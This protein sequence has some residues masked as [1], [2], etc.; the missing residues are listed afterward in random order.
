MPGKRVL[1]ADD[2]KESEADLRRIIEGLGH[3]WVAS[4]VETGTA[5]ISA[6]ERGSFTAV[7]TET[8]L[9]DMTGVELLEKA[10]GVSP[11]TL[12][13][14]MA[15][16]PTRDIIVQ[17]AGC[18]HQLI[19]KPVEPSVFR[20]TLENSQGLHEILD[21]EELQATLASIDS[22]PTRPELYDELT[23]M[24]SSDEPSTVQVADLVEQDTSVT[25]KLLQLANSAFY[26]LPMLVESPRRAVTVL[27][28]DTIQ[29]I[30]LASG[31]FDQFEDPGLPG[32]SIDRIYDH[33]VSIGANALNIAN[34]FGLDKLGAEAS[35]TAGILH[36]IGKLVMLKYFPIELTE[37][38]R[39]A[40]EKSISLYDAEKEIMGVDHAQIGAHLLSLWGLHY[41]VLEA[42]ARHPKPVGLERPEI[43]ALTTVHIAHALDEDSSQGDSD[44]TSSALD[45]DYIERLGLAD[46]LKFLRRLCNTG[47]ENSKRPTPV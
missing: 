40:D 41:P 30:V 42:V 39:L 38:R 45:I 12:R 21:N 25:A 10:R 28:L 17:S 23:T 20:N 13:F 11:G 29:S 24:L 3:E 46:K 18:A 33:S 6:L 14:V 31:V 44:K 26:G 15:A 5:A 7:V 36:D 19:V 27:G 32:I 47:K 1:F 2:Q 16:R 8:K 34:R 22:L 4:I 43:N 37:A 35:F 9:P